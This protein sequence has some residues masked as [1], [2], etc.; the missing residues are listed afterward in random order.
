MSKKDNKPKDI[1][2]VDEST[3]AVTMDDQ[4][5]EL[6]A[7][8]QRL[9]A[10]F[11]NYRKRVEQEKHQAR[12]NGADSMLLSVLPVVDNIDRAIA[13][14]PDELVD[15]NWVKGIVAAKKSVE[16]TLESLGVTKIDSTPGTL[17]NPELHEAIQFNEDSEGE[18]EVVESELQGGY[19][20]N[21][22]PIRHAMVRVERK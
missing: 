15:N 20:R 10:D 14:V 18:S 3:D 19:L 13:H 6:T 7:D 21:G 5:T 9:R 11:E 17:F 2:T 8:L 1:N 16:K 12:T 4:T 22:Q